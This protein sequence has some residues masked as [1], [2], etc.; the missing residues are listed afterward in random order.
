[1]TQPTGD[2]A[3][4]N[5][6]RGEKRKKDMIEKEKEEDKCV[7]NQRSVQDD[8]YC[9]HQHATVAKKEHDESKQQMKKQKQM[10]KQPQNVKKSID[11]S[12]HCIHCD[13]EPCCFIQIESRLCEN[14]EIYFD[15]EDYA[16]DRSA[17]NS[18]RRKRAYQ[19]AAFILW[20]G[21]N[22]RKPHYRCVEDGVRALFPPF[23]GKIIG[24]KTC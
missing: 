12:D 11:G 9:C 23:D 22:Y 5:Y 3:T 17:Y 2:I 14:D 16:K 1:M 19:Y 8:G 15:E 7:E 13:K 10:K 18:G 4:I 24:Y 20:E 21:V 6:K